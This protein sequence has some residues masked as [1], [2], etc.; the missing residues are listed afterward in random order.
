MYRNKNKPKGADDFEAFFE[1]SSYGV[2][3]GYILDLH[4]PEKSVIGEIYC[5]GASIGMARADN[6]TPVTSQKL[7]FHGLHFEIPPKL[8]SKSRKYR[9]QIANTPASFPV[10]DR[11]FARNVCANKPK[12]HISY[13]GGGVIRGWIRTSENEAVHNLKLLCDGHYISEIEVTQ[14]LPWVDN[15]EDVRGFR[16]DI[17]AQLYDG[18]VHSLS[19]LEHNG[20]EIYG[21]P[22][23]I[24]LI[25]RGLSA[26]FKS[27]VLHLNDDRNDGGDLY[28]I[29]NSF[30]KRYPR[31][32]GFELYEN[33]KRL[34]E[35]NSITAKKDTS[36]ILIIQI[37][38]N[39]PLKRDQS[40]GFNQHGITLL[41]TSYQNLVKT[42]FSKAINYDY[43]L[44][45]WEEDTIT[46]EQIHYFVQQMKTG[47]AMIAYCD[48][49]F[50]Q[51]ARKRI[52]PWFRPAWD[53]TMFLS[54]DYISR[55]L[56]LTGRSIKAASDLL[57]DKDGNRCLGWYDLVFGLIS[58]SRH[59]IMH[60][61]KI[62]YSCKK[63]DRI[64]LLNNNSSRAPALVNYL[65]REYGIDSPIIEADLAGHLHIKWPIPKKSPKV[66]IIIPTRDSCSLLKSCVES[67]RKFTDYANYELI[68]VDN[69]S[70]EAE[71]VAYLDFLSG[72][73]VRVIQYDKPFN[74]SDMHNCVM[75]QVAGP[76]VCFMN[77]DV[78][79][80]EPGWLREMVGQLLRKRVGAVGAKLLWPN[81][82]V[83]HGGVVVG[84][85]RLAAHIGNY[86]LA[87][88]P[89]YFW[90]NAES[91]EL[92]AVTAAC[93]VMRKKDFLSLGG[94]DA[95]LFPIAF[96]DVDLCLRLRQ[97]GFRIVWT[98]HARLIHL[99][100]ASR[101]RDM[102][103]SQRA[104]SQREEREFRKKWTNGD[105]QDPYY[106]PNLSQDFLTGPY[107][108]LALDG[109]ATAP[110]FNRR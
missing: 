99:E 83:Q 81:N 14:R 77:N 94:F 73:G 75:Q 106:N 92:S 29:L 40:K 49:D 63:G 24:S 25:S 93:M 55:G 9:V 19:I 18:K 78:S 22:I 16:I 62:L 57:G 44:P 82:L 95:N 74:Y 43:V 64:Q 105:W 48:V 13:N 35:N 96:N 37:G 89:G 46:V 91:R 41:K 2:I 32:I 68:I 98:P 56:C 42:L 71:T 21:S 54:L 11:M 31:S 52:E 61:P 15:E 101:G 108:G 47:E 45:V 3:K 104:R 26:F 12:S 36:N 88:E 50:F 79:V 53:E 87:D 33:W 90:C 65:N 20:K 76:I 70:S 103:P 58:I 27:H 66:S 97:K 67:I 38:L 100:S 1:L 84:I 80:V 69:Q 8:L 4:D 7:S 30:E 60:I 6:E 39:K 5:D 59:R 85:D 109:L 34:H 51:P 28:E 102:T 17:P 107:G 72:Q 86:L 10:V 110:R 23:E